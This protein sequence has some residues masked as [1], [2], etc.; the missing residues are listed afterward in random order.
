MATR[1]PKAK[2]IPVDAL[3]ALIKQLKRA[4]GKEKVR[5]ARLLASTA[6]PAIVTFSALGDEGV[7]QEKQASGKTYDELAVELGYGSRSR[8]TDAVSRHNRRQRGEL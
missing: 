1:D 7:W 2:P 8:V 5:L 4:K 6:G 3:I